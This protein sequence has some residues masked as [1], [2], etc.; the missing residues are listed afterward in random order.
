MPDGIM[1]T[2][3]HA[4]DREKKEFAADLLLRQLNIGAAII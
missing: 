3:K 4:A 2:L 1:N